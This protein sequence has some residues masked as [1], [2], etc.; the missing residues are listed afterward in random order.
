MPLQ[1]KGAAVA[2]AKDLATIARKERARQGGLPAPA[3]EGTPDAALQARKDLTAMGLRYFDS[4]QLLEAVRRNDALAVEL[5][6]AARGV[7]LTARDAD[8]L[9]AL[10]LAQRQN[11]LRMAE[12]LAASPR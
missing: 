11:N 5:F 9:T 12:L 6:V 1:Y 7:D 8:G 3:L 4:G 10:A 2:L